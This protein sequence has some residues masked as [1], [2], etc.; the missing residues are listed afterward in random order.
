M[1]GMPAAHAHHLHMQ[2][3]KVRASNGV[4]ISEPVALSLLSP[5]ERAVP[6]LPG[7]RVRAVWVE[8]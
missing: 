4:G 3:G 1:P 2:R 7:V 5:G 8:G 6:L